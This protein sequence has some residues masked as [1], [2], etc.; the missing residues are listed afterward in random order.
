MY[1]FILPSFRDERPSPTAQTVIAS[2]GYPVGSY[3]DDGQH[4]GHAG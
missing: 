2:H 1:S 4:Q 3:R